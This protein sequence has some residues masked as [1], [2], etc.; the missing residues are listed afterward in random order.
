MNT[1]RLPDRLRRI[2]LAVGR[3]ALP[4]GHRTPLFDLSSLERVEAGIEWMD[5]PI[6]RGYLGLLV[7]VELTVLARTG[8]RLHRVPPHQLAEVL[9]GIARSGRVGRLVVDGLLAPIRVAHFSE[10][11][12]FESLGC[13]F[14]TDAPAD[15]PARWHGKVLPLDE[16]GSTDDLACDA[17]VVGSGAGG[18]VVAARLAEAGLAVLLVEE[19]DFFRRCHFHGRP[20][21]RLRA[22]Y[23]NLGLLPLHG[24]TRLTLPL[25]RT[26]GGST[27]VNSGTCYRAPDEV[28]HRWS[29]AQG[30]TPLTP[31]GMAPYYDKVERFLE[32]APCDPDLW[33]GVA[34]VVIRGCDAL[35]F[36]H[37]PVLR[38]APECDGQAT[39]AFGCPSGAK[40]SAD[41]SYIPRA[42]SCG[43]FAITGATVNRILW[44]GRRAC[45]VELVG[46]PPIQLRAR[47]V[48][49]AAGTVHSP[50]LLGRGL[51]G[52]PPAALGRHMTVHPA[53]MVM[54]LMDEPVR[55]W[56]GVPQSYAIEEFRADGL[57][58][59]GGFTPPDIAAAMFAPV[60]RRSMDLLDRYDRIALFGAMIADTSSGR[61][62]S[63]RAGE[64]VLT[65][66]L[67][68]SDTLR[69]NRGLRILTDVFLAAGAREVIP[70]AGSWPSVR[71]AGD[72]ARL[73]RHR[74]GPGQLDLTAFHP[75]GTCRMGT[76]PGT[77]VV[78]VDH[79]VHGTQG[80]YVVDGSVVPSALGVNPQLTIFAM[81]ERAADRI[82]ALD[83]P[84][85]AG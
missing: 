4:R 25:G 70:M 10:P 71:T 32:I 81:A 83:D 74:F 52:E 68:R 12:Y 69:L 5:P 3:A 22:M 21:T 46:D 15:E 18:S 84:R 60:G 19:G 78:S 61:V 49:L 26:L 47:I 35:G 77:S 50:G 24:N 40:R 44:Q 23:R 31:D 39:C 8:R 65:Y 79:A 30:L 45:G 17:I 29:R 67:N 13:P 33:G 28:L 36:A 55:G 7:A 48:V 9:H 54:A 63:R 2:L 20:T 76:D 14:E 16:I 53:G 80:C 66:W 59:E 62:F 57:L 75:L 56:E 42:L 11:A 41:V 51:P 64:P 43:A 1:F 38:N 34:D 58:F 82:L 27:T 6:R 85:T 37:G 73:G 72:L